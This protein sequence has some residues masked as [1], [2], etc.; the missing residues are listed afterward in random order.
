M[1]EVLLMK[2]NTLLLLLL[3]IGVILIAQPGFAANQNVSNPWPGVVKANQDVFRAVGKEWAVGAVGCDWNYAQKWIGSR[4][5]G[6]RTPKIAE[7]K[8]LFAS[9]GKTSSIGD[10]GVWAER[11]DSS[12]AW[13]FDFINGKGYQIHLTSESFSYR[14]VAVRPIQANQPA[15][16]NPFKAIGKEWNVGPTRLNWQEAQAWV[17]KLGSGWRTPT[18]TELKALSRAVGQTTVI[19]SSAVWSEKNDSLTAWQFKFEWGDGSRTSLR[20]Q[21]WS[22]HAIAVRD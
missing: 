22:I 7:L 2:N 3:V 15:L 12:K 6:W 9:V 21:H 16:R 13:F 8:E 4:G 18:V 10:S 11:A 1:Q 17:K 14:A 19:G 20:Y 5:G